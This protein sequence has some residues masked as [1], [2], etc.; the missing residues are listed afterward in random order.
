MIP[1]LG[2]E[3]FLLLAGVML[4]ALVLM[5]LLMSRYVRRMRGEGSM[6]QIIKDIESSARKKGFHAL[7]DRVVS[8]TAFIFRRDFFAFAAMLLL[9]LGLA[10][11]LMWA[12]AALSV[13]LVLYLAYYSHRRLRA[14]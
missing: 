7:L 11:A 6:L 12:V 10:G 8:K 13:L 14:R 2:Q 5:F 1:G 9:I 4:I 3:T